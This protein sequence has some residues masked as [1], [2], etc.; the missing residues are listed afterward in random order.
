[1]ISGVEGRGGLFSEGRKVRPHYIERQLGPLALPSTAPEDGR[2]RGG[3]LPCLLQVPDHGLGG[4][5]LPQKSLCCGSLKRDPHGPFC[6]SFKALN[7][8]QFIRFHMSN[9][10]PQIFR[11]RQTYRRWPISGCEISL[12]N[13]LGG[14]ADLL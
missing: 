11:R 3:S 13:G 2:L 10:G 6:L 5:R 4:V 14:Q 8:Y 9:I 1:M 12:P 7:C